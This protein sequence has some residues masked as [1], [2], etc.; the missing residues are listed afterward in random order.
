MQTNERMYVI[1][2]IDIDLAQRLNS[3]PLTERLDRSLPFVESFGRNS[4]LSDA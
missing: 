1:R 4:P 2:R 3:H